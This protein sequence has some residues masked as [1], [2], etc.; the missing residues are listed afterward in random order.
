MFADLLARRFDLDLQRWRDFGLGPIVRR[1]LAAAHP[2]GTAL[3]I[4]TPEGA[5]DGSFAGLDAGGALRL[6]L[7]S[8][9]VRVVH[10]GEVRLAAAVEG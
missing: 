2:E 4:D 8:G 6:R 5:L 7:A 9:A 1:W 3:S 10:S